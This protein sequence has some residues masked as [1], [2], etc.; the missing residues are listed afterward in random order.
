MF[1]GRINKAYPLPP[2][3]QMYQKQDCHAR[4]VLL[5]LFLNFIYEFVQNIPDQ[6][7]LILLLLILAN[8]EVTDSLTVNEDKYKVHG[9]FLRCF[10]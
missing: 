5:L 7:V 8:V 4:G 6:R 10:W 9:L 3:E 1:P 2:L